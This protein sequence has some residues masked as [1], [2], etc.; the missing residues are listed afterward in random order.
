MDHFEYRAGRLYAEGIDVAQLASRFGSPLYVYSRATL[1]RHW[2]AFDAALADRPHRVCYAVKANGNLAVLDVL[3]RLG[4]GFDIVSVGELERCRRVGA[5][6]ARIVFSGVGKRAEEME[7]ALAVGVGCFN[8]ESAQELERLEAVAAAAEE[9]A[10]PSDEL[11]AD[12][13]FKREVYL[14]DE[15]LEE[16]EEILIG[17]DVGVD[18]AIEAIARAA[19]TGK[20]GDGK[21]FVEPVERVVRIRTGEE[22]DGA[23]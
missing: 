1:E 21:I 4:A 3:A 8:L 18:A 11:H 14:S 7:R 15:F 9:A 10:D 20:I 17:A 16:V 6:P 22:G 12:A 5:D 2:R 13:A 19:H 23:V